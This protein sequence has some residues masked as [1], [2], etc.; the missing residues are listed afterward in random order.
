MKFTDTDIILIGAGN[1]ASHLARVLSH[2][3]LRISGICSRTA[4]SARAL[5]K[6][7]HCPGCANVA[8]IPDKAKFYFICVDD[9]KLPEV[10]DRM[11]DTQ[12]LV[13]HT[14]GSQPLDILRKFP[15]RG[16][17]YPLQTFSKNRE[18]DFSI[19]P[20]CIEAPDKKN[21]GTLKKIA[22]I[23]SED[24]RIMDSDQRKNT[25][26]AAVFASNFSNFMFVA[27]SDILRNYKTDF[28]ILI[29]LILEFFD[30][31]I[32][33]DAWKAQTGPAIRGDWS[34]IEQH[35]SLLS[36]HP[37][38]QDIYRTISGQIIAKKEAES[39]TLKK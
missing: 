18:T 13:M 25:H 11:P 19:V 38:Y 33:M 1:L 5:A 31:T 15:N 23:L 7:Y 9:E 12:G 10:V 35:L 36:D 32:S 3:G 37:G 16:V 21:L 28:N 20:V 39:I 27:A 26:L 4:K 24:V 22:R 8:L 29:P 30:K 6:P 2:K 34:V 17:F 14:S